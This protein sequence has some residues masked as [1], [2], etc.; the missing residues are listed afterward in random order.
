MVE[1]VEGDWRRA[2]GTMARRYRKEDR[3]K[4][5]VGESKHKTA[6]RGGRM[7]ASMLMRLVEEPVGRI[8]DSGRRVIAVAFGR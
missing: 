8:I 6:G 7:G 2:M 4:D 5:I 1:E 3:L